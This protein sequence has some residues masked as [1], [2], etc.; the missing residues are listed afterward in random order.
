MNSKLYQRMS[1]SKEG[2]IRMQVH[3]KGGMKRAGT[4]VKER[5][6]K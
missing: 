6:D 2:E 1:T 5:S 4:E 3:T